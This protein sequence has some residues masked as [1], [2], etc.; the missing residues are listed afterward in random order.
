MRGVKKVEKKIIV[1]PPQISA[2][3]LEEMKRFFASTSIPR[4]IESRKEELKEGK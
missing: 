4:I 1:N 2:D 3:T